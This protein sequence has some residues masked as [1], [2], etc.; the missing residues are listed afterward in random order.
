M[1]KKII[2][3]LVTTCLVGSHQFIKAQENK[4]QELG[5][6]YDSELQTDFH[7]N[8]NHVDLLYLSAEYS[9]RNNLKFSAATISIAKTREERLIDDL[10]VFSNIEEDNLPLA[11]A[12]ADMEWQIN[13]R[14]TL[15]MGI[16][17][18][19]EDYF[20]SPVTSLFTNSSCG[21]FPTLSC[22]LPIANYPLASVGIHY[23]YSSQHFNLLSSIYN[24][25][26][27]N[28]WAGRENVWKVSPKEDGIFF[29]TQG[30]WSLS[31]G[32]YFLGGCLHTGTLQESSTKSTLWCYTE[33]KI[34][35]YFSLIADYSHVFGKGCECLD[36]AG[37]GL[38]YEQHN[39]TIGLFSDYA[40][41]CDNT[42][43]ATELTC[44]FQFNKS[45]F[46]QTSCHLISMS[47]LHPIG[48]IRLGIRL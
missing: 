19:N 44:K 28:R 30:E 16:R 20:T 4:A 42:E 17:N 7:G 43:Y 40:R 33:Q 27:Y 47:S 15:F 45:V 3:F 23:T 13:D 39:S 22:N 1:M 10:Q 8:Y 11:L 34:S 9:L 29:I 5:I 32:K 24:G 38:Q 25:R 18:V 14:H 2:L 12:V 35:E 48:I 46:I 37:L 21:I 26:G 41:F 6:W 31:N 36:F